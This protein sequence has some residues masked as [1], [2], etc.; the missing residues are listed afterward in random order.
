MYGGNWNFGGRTNCSANVVKI[1][2]TSALYVWDEY[3]TDGAYLY[4]IGPT[5]CTS[6][7]GVS[8]CINA[9]NDTLWPDRYMVTTYHQIWAL[10]GWQPPYQET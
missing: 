2:L 1:T 3:F 7:S 6:P 8:G 4:T 5:T 10:P 9:Y